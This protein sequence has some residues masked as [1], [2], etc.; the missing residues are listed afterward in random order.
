MFFFLIQ[1]MV[2]SYQDCLGC[3][4]H[5]SYV[6]QI[7]AKLL[8]V[9]NI[10]FPSVKRVHI[11]NYHIIVLNTA[12]F[13]SDGS[14]VPLSLE[15]LFKDTQFIKVKD[16]LAEMEN[17]T[18][19]FSPEYSAVNPLVAQVN[20]FCWHCQSLRGEHPRHFMTHTTSLKANKTVLHR[21]INNILLLT[22][23]QSQ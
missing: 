2:L 20:P 14:S 22:T 7:L 15:Q 4:K 12:Q 11:L 16:V 17:Y 21:D 1:E 5:V 18:L 8:R 13:H 9:I 19:Y 3:G 23:G 6:F 10:F